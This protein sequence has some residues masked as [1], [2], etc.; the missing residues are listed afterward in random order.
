MASVDQRTA[1]PGRSEQRQH[2][3]R[4]LC[5]DVDRLH[6][7]HGPGGRPPVYAAHDDPVVGPALALIHTQPGRPWT[8]ASLA[9]A[10]GSSRAGL[11][12]RFT[13]LVGQTPVAYLASWRLSH[14]AALLTT[15]DAIGTAVIKYPQKSCAARRRSSK[16]ASMSQ[17]IL[18]P[19]YWSMTFR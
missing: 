18:S 8:V 6:R 11:A 14:A 7:R 1:D 5:R 16:L 15:T 3:R 13:Q 2:Q 19:S 9:T 17:R 10:V 4:V 12:R